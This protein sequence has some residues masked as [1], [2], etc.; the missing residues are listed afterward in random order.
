MGE[1]EEKYEKMITINKTCNFKKKC[2]SNHELTQFVTKKDRQTC[3]I[4]NKEW[5]AETSMRGCRICDYDICSDCLSCST[6]IIIEGRNG[7]VLIPGKWT[8]HETSDRNEYFCEACTNK[9][10]EYI[11][12]YLYK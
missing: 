7:L 5:P 11:E 8:S 9:M 2:P 1:K 12:G 10:K 3:R 6:K 4:C